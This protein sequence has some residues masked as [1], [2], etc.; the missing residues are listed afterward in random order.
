L[1]HLHPR[2][3]FACAAAARDR[4]WARDTPETFRRGIDRAD[5]EIEDFANCR[6]GLF[7]RGVLAVPNRAASVPAQR[8]GVSRARN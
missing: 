6:F 7:A 3:G 5:I 1:V 2:E 8:Y 4:G